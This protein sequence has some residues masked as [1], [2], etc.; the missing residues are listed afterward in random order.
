MVDAPF[1]VARQRQAIAQRQQAQV[2]ALIAIFKS[3]L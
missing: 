1:S 2:D 3:P